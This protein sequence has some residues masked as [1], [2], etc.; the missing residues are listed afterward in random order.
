[1]KAVVSKQRELKKWSWRE[2]SNPRPPDYKSDAL[3][4]ELRQLDVEVFTSEG[5]YDPQQMWL[6]QALVASKCRNQIDKP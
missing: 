1:M 4:T 6:G 2:E 3:P 5:A